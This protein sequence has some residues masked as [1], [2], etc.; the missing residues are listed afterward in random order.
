[1]INNKKNDNP[2]RIAQVIGKMNSGGVES[3]VM[4]YYSNINK[5]KV[6]FDFIVDSDSTFIPQE[7]I[8]RLGGRIFIIPPYQK[9]F[10]YSI[11]LIK[12]FKKNKYKI[13]HSHLNTLS[14]FPLFCAY[15]SGV[16]IRI[17]HSH[18][19]SNPKEKKRNFIKNML[20]PFSKL[21]A[22]NY[23][24]CSEHAGRWLFGNKAFDS[25]KVKIIANAI[26]LQRFKFDEK[27][28]IKIRKQLNL[29]G[30]LVIRSHW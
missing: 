18:S 20:K 28:R 30:K 24:A 29:E 21:F 27:T 6:Q 26:D 22:N 15:I 10:K 7:E 8:E 5:E 1:M 14:I 12:I 16:K 3:F 11:S 19:T 23:F 9:I 2:I 13:V 4:N 25:E 17:A